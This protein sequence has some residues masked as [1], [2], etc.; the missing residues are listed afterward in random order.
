MKQI[1]LQCWCLFGFPLYP[2][3]SETGRAN[4]NFSIDT[5]RYV[6]SL[7]RL[8]QHQNKHTLRLLEELY[9]MQVTSLENSR[10]P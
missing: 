7:L 1:K 4:S 10:L 8:H 5:F 9:E 2:P 6:K 3:K